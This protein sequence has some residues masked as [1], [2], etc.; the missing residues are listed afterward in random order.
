MSSRKAA[1]REVNFFYMLTFPLSGV[2]Y[3]LALLLLK[4]IKVEGAEMVLITTMAAQW[5]PGIAAFITGKRFRKLLH[6]S[7]TVRFTAVSLILCIL[8]PV[9][10]IGTQ[11]ILTSNLGIAPISSAFFTSVP[12][13]LFSIFTVVIGS[14]GEEIG[15]RGYLY[16]VLKR[17]MKPWLASMLTGLLWGVWHFT[18]I[19]NQGI[20]L[21]LVFVL[22][23][24][25]LGFIASYVIDKSRGSI[26]P[27]TFFLTLYNLSVMYFLYERESLYGHAIAFVVLCVIVLCI[28]IADRNY[29]TKNINCGET[30]VDEDGE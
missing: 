29:F 1:L 18:K 25:P 21:Y 9:V 22:S 11:S 19:F 7:L 15:W 26:V 6:M 16:P 12:L 17:E 5:A 14:F 4:G 10:S 20:A 27:S 24:I 28:R 2:L 30:T 23:L 8:V 3:G 13:S